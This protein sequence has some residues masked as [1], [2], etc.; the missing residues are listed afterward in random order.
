MKKLNTSNF[1]VIRECSRITSQ[2]INSQSLSIFTM[3][4]LEALA[5]QKKKK[6]NICLKKNNKILPPGPY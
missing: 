5:K 2:K 4:S 1:K 3:T 6:N